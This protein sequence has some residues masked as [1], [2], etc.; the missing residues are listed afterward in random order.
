MRE[1]ALPGKHRRLEPVRVDRWLEDG[2]TI[3][4]LGQTVTVGHVPGHCP[5][6]LVF[7]SSRCSGAAFAGDALFRG[8]RGA[9]RPAGSGSFEALEKSIRTRIYTL[10]GETAVFPGHGGPT[11][12]GEERQ[13]N[14]YVRG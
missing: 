6:S 13:S 7:Y 14:P 11:T 10:P 12:V 2:E 4:A 1:L 8:S 5:G 9:D 3:E